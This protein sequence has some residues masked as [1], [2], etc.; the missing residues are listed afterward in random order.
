MATPE[1]LAAQS[2]NYLNTNVT[3]NTG[4]DPNVYFNDVSGQAMIGADGNQYYF[5]SRDYVNRGFI[6]Q[7]NGKDYQFYNARFLNKDVFDKAQQFT[8]PDGTPG[9]V[10]KAQDAINLKIANSEGLPTYGGYDLSSGRPPIVGIGYPNA[11]GNEHLNT[12][13]YVSMPQKVSDKRVEQ[14]YITNDGTVS[15]ANFSGHRGYEYY[16]NGWLADRLRA[17]LPTVNAIMPIVLEVISPG[18]GLGAI[19]ATYSASTAATIQALTTGNIEKGVVDLAKIYA[20]GQVSDLVSK[21]VSAYMPV[22]ELGKV[23]TAILGNAGTSAIVAGIYGKDVGKAFIDGGIAAGIGSVAGS[24]SGF[25]QLPVPIQR[26]FAAAVTTSL[27][28]KSQKEMDAATLQAAITAGL[29]AIANGLEANSKIQR[30]RL[31]N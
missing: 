19:Y 3:P 30:L 12:L 14:N 13:S 16:V 2:A 5:A 7:M 26:V 17:G 25:S 20:A 29:G 24:I 15:G 1:E 10:W 4:G 22:A 6:S 28:G 18:M 21:G 23:A 31:M 27:Q 11:T 8:A 9:F